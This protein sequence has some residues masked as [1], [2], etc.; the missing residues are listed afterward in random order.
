[1]LVLEGHLPSAVVRQVIRSGKVE[2]HAVKIP[3]FHLVILMQGPNG[4]TI[5]PLNRI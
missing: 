4:Y 5:H 2:M 3:C 1:M